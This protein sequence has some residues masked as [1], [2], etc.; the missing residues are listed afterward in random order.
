MNKSNIN[1]KI[2]LGTVQ[3]GLDYGI[4]NN[5]GKPSNETVFNILNTARQNGIEILDTAE[6]YGS[7]IPTIGEYHHESISKFKIVSKFS[8]NVDTLP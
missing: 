8:N 5:N 1:N 6:A 7:A 2:I 4:N 3:F